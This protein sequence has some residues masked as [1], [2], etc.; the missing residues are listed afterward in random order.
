MPKATA[1]CGKAV[2]E[3]V[4][5]TPDDESALQWARNPACV[6]ASNSHDTL[7]TQSL[8]THLRMMAGAQALSDAAMADSLAMVDSLDNIHLTLQHRPFEQA[9]S[10]LNMDEQAMSDTVVTG[11]PPSYIKGDRIKSLL[12]AQLLH[13]EPPRKV[14]DPHIA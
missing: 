7:T 6:C 9:H 3:L 5:T 4:V 11:D 13:E 1:Q 10:G 12:K 8:Q 2:N 14:T